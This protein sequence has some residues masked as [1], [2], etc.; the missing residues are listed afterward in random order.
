MPIKST[1]SILP[2][3]NE[4]VSFNEVLLIEEDLAIVEPSIENPNPLQP[5]PNQITYCDVTA[6]HLESGVSITIS[7]LPSTQV[8]VT[9][10]GTYSNVFDQKFWQ[11]KNTI[12]SPVTT[13]I[14]TSSIPESFFALTRYNPDKRRTITLSYT[15]TTNLGSLV[16]TKDILND[17]DSGKITFQQI[18]GRQQVP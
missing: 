16:V 12:D 4:G 2:A 1:P 7:A 11:Y 17:W 14:S 8:T 6:S 9:I 3:T 13:V 18:L 10:S 5:T 15:I